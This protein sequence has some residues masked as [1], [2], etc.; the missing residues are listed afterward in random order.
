MTSVRCAY[1]CIL[2]CYWWLVVGDQV[3]SRFGRPCIHNDRVHR[4]CGEREIVSAGVVAQL[5]GV[6]VLRRCR[7]LQRTAH[8][9][10]HSPSEKRQLRPKLFTL[11]STRHWLKKDVPALP[12][13]FWV[14]L[15]SGSSTASFN[16]YA[17]DAHGWISTPLHCADAVQ[18]LF[19]RKAMPRCKQQSSSRYTTV[20]RPMKLWNT[21]Q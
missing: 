5:C 7:W 16:L 14:F 11:L 9:E 21:C 12:N 18:Y 1:C 15:S 6:R 2:P 3:N 20:H 10:G 17:A 8:N 13:M 4:A 19:V